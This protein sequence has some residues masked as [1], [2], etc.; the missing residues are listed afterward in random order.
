MAPA[1]LQPSLHHAGIA[2][3][4][5]E[6]SIDFYSEVLDGRLLFRMD[7]MGDESGFHDVPDVRFSL[8]MLGFASGSVELLEYHSPPDARR[9]RIRHCDLGSA[10]LAFQV[11]DVAQVVHALQDRGVRMLGRTLHVP[12]GP[13][14]GTV[15]AFIQDPDGNRIEFME[16]P[17]S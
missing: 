12:A 1:V 2:V 9:E 13:A 15:I 6:R 8:A 4:N 17:Q 3:S 5:L 11:P 14:A 10:H 7:D 16:L